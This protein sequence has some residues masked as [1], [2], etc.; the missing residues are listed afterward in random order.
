[1]KKILPSLKKLARNPEPLLIALVVVLVGVIGFQLSSRVGKSDEN[2]HDNITISVDDPSESLE[3]A[4]NFVWK[5][6]PEDPKRISISKIQVESLIQRVGV[7]QHS[8]VAVPNN[9]HLAAWFVESVQPGKTGLSII[10]AH[11]SGRSTDGLFKNLHT[12]TENDEFTV[13]R[14]DGKVLSYKVMQVTTVPEADSA[15]VLF[16]QDPKV[17]SQLNLITCGGSYDTAS[18][19]YTERTIV[20]SQLISEQ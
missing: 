8:K 3:D 7:D 5:G 16:S 17:K 11:V 1:M 13:E 12:L 6:G 2:P 19:Q 20:T 14:G 15:A 10:D 4:K 18:R 9:V